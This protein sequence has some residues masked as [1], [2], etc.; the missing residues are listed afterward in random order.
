MIEIHADCTSEYRLRLSGNVDVRVAA[1][2]HLALVDALSSEKNIV[3]D[4]TAIESLDASF[5]QLLL[6]TKRTSPTPLTLKLEP[7]SEALKW[8]EMA[9]LKSELIGSE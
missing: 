3:I 9:G 7:H 5:L 1:D 8:I 6:A 2:L 4:C